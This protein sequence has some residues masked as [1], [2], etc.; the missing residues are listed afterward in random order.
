MLFLKYIKNNF[1]LIFLLFPFFYKA[2]NNNGI[3]FIK[4]YP[5]NEYG[6]SPNNWAI[7][8][9]KR[10]VM[11]FGNASGVLEFDGINWT[12]IP[13][14]N[15]SVVRSI[16]IDSAGTIFVGAVGEFGYLKANE[17]GALVYQSLID[18]LP[19]NE[20]DF[21]EV[22]K[23]YATPNGIYFQTFSKLIRLKNNSLKIWKPESSFHFSFFLNNKFYINEKQFGL[24]CLFND[25]LTLI[26]GGETF[27]DLR[28]YGM[29]PYL[30]NKI[31]IACREK[32][33]MLLNELATYKDSALSSFKSEINNYLIDGQVYGGVYLKNNTYCFATLKNGVYIINSSGKII[34][35][36]NKKTGLQDDIIKSVALDNQNDLWI[37]LGNGISRAEIS[38]PLF[39]FSDSEGLN[40][41]IEDIT[42]YKNKLYVATSL[43]VFVQDKGKFIP[44]KKITSG[45]WSLKKI[46]F[47]NDTIL[48]ASSESGIFSINDFEGKLIKEGFGYTLCQSA[49]FP[50]R[51][52]V[53]MNDGL[54]SL[55][56]EKNKWIDEDYL[57]GLDVEIRGIAE[58]NDGNL[59]LGSPFDGIIYIDWNTK[60]KSK[61]ISSWGSSFNI[62]NYDTTAGIPAMKYNLPYRF[63]N[64]VLFATTNGIYE[65]DKKN[66]RFYMS[67]FLKKQLS[68]RQIFRLAAK[69]TCS[70]WLFTVVEALSNEVGLAYCDNNNYTWYSQPFLRVSERE[71]HAILPD[72][73]NI[74]WFGGPDGL[75]RYD[76]SIIKNYA[77]PFNS[78]I[79]LVKA[80]NDSIFCG[81][82]TDDKTKNISLK[83][84]TSFFPILT[85]NNNSLLFEYTATNFCAEKNNLFNV[86]LEGFDENWSGW[87]NKSYKEYTNLKEGSY[88]FH[89][90]AKN[91]YGTISSE[92]TF[93]FTI[94]APWYRHILAYIFY[95]ILFLTILF[96]FNAV[97]TKQL[98][99]RQEEL[100]VKIS[101]A[102]SEIKE[103]KH[104]IEEKHKEIT[105]SINYAERIQRSFIATQE[106]LDDNLA[107]YFVFFKPKDVVSGDF[108]WVS[109]LINGNFAL[110][111][112][113]STG[114]GVPGAIMSLLNITSLEKAI[115]TKTAPSEILDDTRK[116]II[117]RLKKDGSP[118]GGKDGMDCSLCVYDFKNLKLYISAANNPVWIVRENNVIEIKPD[119]MPVGKHDKQDMPFTQREVDLQVGDLVYTLTDGF[120]D[121]FGGEKGKKF[122]SKNLRELLLANAHLSTLQQKT[123]LEKTFSDWVGSLEQVDDVTV[124]G[125]KI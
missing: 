94:L 45:T 46:N 20:R 103:Q 108:Y 64:K 44:I 26:K 66:K 21:A 96:G 107:D 15:N 125:I 120:P 99:V 101:E 79:R 75:L 56:F 122:M 100:K 110:V 124:I 38:S 22:W 28:I 92:A 112:A 98:K 104:L 40:G 121:Q 84:P 105:D 9:D 4:N 113:D 60:I 69:G 50:Q 6:S 55:R 117:D 90:K 57:D 63:N 54:S 119:K 18:K 73:N 25:S 3:P 102:T 31:L 13:V 14:S 68:G 67:P 89:V 23:T 30:N 80:G 81:N 123:L 53:G 72:Q 95:V 83:Q 2:Q 59:W 118:E 11:Y 71:I 97:R 12:L 37:A 5:P 86:F 47:I 65:F 8:Q 88:T 27:A 10:G 33:L 74:T 7:A 116:I 78:L 24:K 115:E 62:L 16:A 19:K 32:G 76:A 42:S 39:T 29:Y 52:Y 17:K 58:D 111:T 77:D 41:S 87:S 1:Y 114:H 85:Y 109:R 43:G 82:F 70:V 91:I 51:V 106:I 61:F 34:N 93:Q 35:E 48:L 49:K 36:I